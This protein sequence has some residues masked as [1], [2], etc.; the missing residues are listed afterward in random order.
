MGHIK[1]S[2]LTGGRGYLIEQ[3]QWVTA[4]SWPGTKG[5]FEGRVGLVGDSLLVGRLDGTVGLIDMVDSSTYLN[6]ELEHCKRRNGK[7]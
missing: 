3:P 4:L 7:W 2:F 6:F 1:I 5:M